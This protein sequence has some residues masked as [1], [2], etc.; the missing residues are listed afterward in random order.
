MLLVLQAMDAGG[1]DGAVKGILAGANPMGVEVHGFGVPS[2]EE[3]DH[4]FLWR[5]HARVP[6]KERIG[7]FNRSHYED[8][9][10][11]RVKKIVPEP[12]WKARYDTIN[13]FEGGLVAAGTSLV[14]VMLHISA[15][16]QRA[17][18]QARIDD[19][20]KRWKFRMG[21]LDDR[22]LWPKFMEAYDDALERTSTPAA[23]WFC[24]PANQKWYRDWAVL[25]ILV[26]TLEKLDPKY[27]L[28]AEL[29]GV[30]V[31]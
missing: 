22:Q 31:K 30:T 6:G 20:T 27:P 16:E 26:T 25:S 13:A 15:E 4:D 10:V 9:L 14:K 5:I 3:R 21:D 11:V 8:V 24:V 2:D 17:R 29:D 1:K 12:I 19:P 23:P 28:H 18:L 7:I